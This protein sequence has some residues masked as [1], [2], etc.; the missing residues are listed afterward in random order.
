MK[1]VDCKTLQHKRRVSGTEEA[2]PRSLRLSP[3]ILSCFHLLYYIL[4]LFTTIGHL[5]GPLWRTVP[6]LGQQLLI[7]FEHICPFW[8]HSLPRGAL[9]AGL[10][11][12]G[13]F[14][15][16]FVRG[17]NINSTGQPCCWHWALLPEQVCALIPSALRLR[18]GA[19]LQLVGDKHIMK[20]FWHPIKK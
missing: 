14:K 13:P 2:Q 5:F 17:H 10:L 7:I 6:S 11:F 4:L 1:L 15:T 16:L 20:L 9:L 12:L 3:Q 8:S 18:T 19:A